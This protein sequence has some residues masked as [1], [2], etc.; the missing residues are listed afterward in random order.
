MLNSFPFYRQRD[1]MDCGATCLK[2][3][4]KFY[5]KNYELPYLRDR[6][7]IDRDGA[8]L[9]G[10]A[11]AAESIGF[12]TMAVKLPFKD[13]IQED[14]V[15]FIAHW[16][17]RHYVVV[18]K[19]TNSHV[20]IADPAHDKLK[21]THKEFQ[22]GWYSDVEGSTEQGVA[23][24][25]EATPDFYKME[26]EKTDKKTFGFLITYFYPYKKLIFQLFIGLLAG[27][28]LQLIFP[29]LTQSLV[30]SGIQ[31]KDVNFVNLILIAQLVLYL[32][33]VSVEFIRGW[34]LLHLSARINISLVS[35]FLIKL[36]KLPLGFFDS[37]MIGDLL[38]RIND[39]SRVRDFLTTST[40][41]TIFSMF[42]LVVFGIV[43]FI[44][45]PLIFVIFTIGAV[46]YF[47]WVLLF[48]SKRKE[49]DY[50]MFDQLSANQSKVYQL[51]QSIQ[52]IKLTGS[53][54]QKRWE[55]ERIQARMFRINIQ[56]LSLEQWQG[57]GAT[58]ITQ[59]KNILISF[60]SAK[61]VINGSMTFGEMLSVQYIIGQLNTP[62]NQL[63]G[64]IQITQNAKISLDRIGEVHNKEE[65]EED[66]P[67]V[68]DMVPE[69]KTIQISN[70]SFQYGGPD[71]DK[72]LND[73]SLDIPVGKITAVVGTSGSGKTTL[74]KLLLKF[75]TN[76]KGEIKIG[77]TSLNNI[78]ARVWRSHCGSV[79]QDG[80]IFSDSIANNIAVGDDT[81]DKQK[82]LQSVRIANIEDFI[83]HLPLGYNTKIGQEGVGVSQGQRQRLLIARSIYKN[84][85]Y[86][87]FDEATNSLDANNEK[88]I[89][90]NLNSFFKGKT[91]VIVAHRLSTVKNADNIVVLEKGKLVEQGTHNDLVAKKGAYY[92][93]VKNQLELGN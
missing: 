85:D 59:V 4:A 19:I 5:G 46:L 76:Y 42:N 49:L 9:S 32:S 27:S 91:A 80:Y 17:Q 90:E 43:L 11:H 93:L 29:F 18:Y 74:I 16:R 78:S 40:L 67:A 51:I 7:F 87:F 47:V 63:I 82:L 1:A 37:K 24:L 52:E 71:S 89:V 28:L 10:L 69:N 20:Y 72:V 86:F 73:I 36:M 62:L 75:Y 6:S 33:Q 44:F 81:I 57:A 60:I 79:M 45:N 38:Q 56:N 31:Y 77:S 3:I 54:M 65:E 15:P 88:A 34:I 39:H 35:D 53:E 22:D 2:M 50:K 14:V 12:K 66:N 26:G 13:L 83:N 25:M 58:L 64:F 23:L 70:L 61:A 92:E 8:S 55:W 68:I 84:P 48:L 41:S 30:D 21:L